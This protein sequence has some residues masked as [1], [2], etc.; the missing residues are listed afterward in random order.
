MD[1]LLQQQ[2]FETE[3]VRNHVTCGGGV[4]VRGHGAKGDGAEHGGVTASKHFPL[5]P[6]VQAVPS[7]TALWIRANRSSV[8]RV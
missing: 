4:G 3:T 1:A 6:V 8:L 2:S 7:H 5:G